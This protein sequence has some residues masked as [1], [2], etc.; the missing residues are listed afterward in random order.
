MFGNYA[1]LFSVRRSEVLG[2]AVENS[3]RVSPG[4][5][6]GEAIVTDPG[7]F[8]VGLDGQDLLNVKFYFERSW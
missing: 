4:V 1:E 7:A 8:G 3:S 2:A 6:A 5:G